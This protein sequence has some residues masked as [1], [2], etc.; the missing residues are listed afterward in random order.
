MAVVT[1]ISPLL[2]WLTPFALGYEIKFLMIPVIFVVFVIWELYKTDRPDFKVTEVT[3]SNVLVSFR[4]KA[5]Y[6]FE[7]LSDEGATFFP[8]FI[9]DTQ[10]KFILTKTELL[11]FE[12]LQKLQDAPAVNYMEVSQCAHKIALNHKCRF[13]EMEHIFLA[14]I[15]NIS[16]IDQ[17]L[18]TYGSSSESIENAILWVVTERE[19]NARLHFWQEDYVLPKMGGTGRGMTGRV[20]P[21][22]DSISEDFTKRALYEPT[23]KYITHKEEIK[24][25]AELLSSSKV[26]VLIIGEPGSGK[27]T[28]IKNL[29]FTVMKGTEY[30]S[31]KFKRIVSLNAGSLIAG[32]RSS[33]EVAQKIKKVMDEVEKSGDI[34]LFIDEIHNLVSDTQDNSA[35]NASIFSILEP[36][37]ASSK[38]QFIGATNK[39]NFRK[40]VEPNGSF[41]RL[42]QIV[43]IPQASKEDTLEVL[44]AFG[45]QLET[46]YRVLISLPALKKIIELSDKLIH[47]RVFPDKAID[48]LS[49]TVASVSKATKYVTSEEVAKEISQITHVPVSNI[50]ED[51]SRKLLNIEVEMKKRVIGQDGAVNQIGGAL[52]RA[53]AGMRNENKPIAS[54]LFVGT[55][56][57]GKTET[58]KA[59]ARTYFGSEKA[60]I[61]LDMSEYQQMDSINRLIGTPDGKSKGILAEAVRSAPFAM[62]L[63]D[64]IEKAHPNI[65]L[66]FLQVLDDGRLTDSSGRVID[67]TNTIIIATS[68]V[69]TS[70]IQT[71]AVQ[72][73]TFEQMS[74]SALKDVH[75]KFAPEFLNRFSGIIVFRPLTLDDV[76]RIAVLM[77]DRVKTAAETKG[78]KVFFKAELILELVKRGFSPQW[79][80]RPLARVIED[81]VES[82][83]AVKL[84]SRELKMGDTVYL[85]LEVLQELNPSQS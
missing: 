69:G 68:N 24:K 78:V 25:I 14:L 19:D 39:E 34:I 73:G 65:L 64:E 22:L 31:I 50:S 70:G 60:M 52:R 5:K 36:Y 7:K 82:Y 38:I 10:I 58:A 8:K 46:R 29:A 56:G 48:I 9:E 26:N 27:T 85:G 37:L 54:F 74:E 4:P 47:D 61:R 62:I 35:E 44:K 30:D 32:T 20:T 77:L 81:T 15:N 76:Q 6:V 57:V 11:N 42:F 28:I 72:N 84:L 79:G 63:L 75:E 13:V 66:T 83:L 33:G 17:I 53:R 43:D 45:R 49:R 2:W 21:A 80:A 71:I 59:L 41:A 51:E 12:F 67:F 16:K 23:S 1:V 55:T 18:A 40:Y 3:S